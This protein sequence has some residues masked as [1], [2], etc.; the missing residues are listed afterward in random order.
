MWAMYIWAATK[1]QISIPASHPLSSSLPSPTQVVQG[2]LQRVRHL[3]EGGHP[4]YGH[5]LPGLVD[6]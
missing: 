6:I 4:L 5:D 3:R 1:A 2:G